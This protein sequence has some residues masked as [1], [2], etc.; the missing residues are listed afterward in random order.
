MMVEWSRN[1]LVESFLRKEE[2]QRPDELSTTHET[3]LAYVS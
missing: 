3:Y 2:T 1:I